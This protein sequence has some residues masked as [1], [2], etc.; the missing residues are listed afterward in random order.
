M[1]TQAIEQTELNIPPSVF[2]K[3]LIPG[4]VK[5]AMK[6]VSSSDLWK[7]KTKEIGKL[8]VLDDLNVRIGSSSL[9]DHIRQLANSMKIQGFKNSK[10]IEVFILQEGE[11]SSMYVADGHCRLKAL[12]IALA[13]GAEIEQIPVVTLPTKG[14]SLQ[15]IVAGLVDNNSGKDLTS[16]EKALV[17]KRLFNYGWSTDKIGQRYGYSGTNV[18]ILLCAAGAPNSI[19]AMMQSGEV[20]M[21][22][23][24]EMIRKHGENAVDLL[25]RGLANAKA[26]G[27]TSV[28]PT[29]IPGVALGK[30]IKR[31]AEPLYKAAK[32]IAEDPAFSSLSQENQQVLKA[33]IAS[34]AEKEAKADAKLKAQSGDQ[35]AQP[36]A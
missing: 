32:S 10:P 8:K 25:K 7:I 19:V 17:C 6:G 28:T 24:V 31:E 35:V 34:I 26:N 13:E 3:D 14:M 15:D 20:A 9:D 4:S 2:E 27:K 16:F 29:Y 23:A 12:Q 5:S 33:L 30:V 22:T 21:S 11:E 36:D 18:E 1:T